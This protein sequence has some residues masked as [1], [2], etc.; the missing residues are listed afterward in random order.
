M[1]KTTLVFCKGG[2]R[3]LLLLC[4]ILSFVGMWQSHSMQEK[5]N[6]ISSPNLCEKHSRTLSQDLA[7]MRH[8]QEAYDSTW[9]QTDQ[10]EKDP[11]FY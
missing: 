4:G 7:S 10:F 3:L 9:M 5:S 6:N 8:S 1:L 2:P 11:K